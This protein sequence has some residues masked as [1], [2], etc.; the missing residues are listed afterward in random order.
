MMTDAAAR[1][2]V[3]AWLPEPGIVRRCHRESHDT[4][5]LHLELPDQADTQPR[6]K[7][8]SGQFNMLY[9]FGIG[10][11]PISISGVSSS[12]GYVQH[13]VKAAGALTR[14]M[15]E[16]KPDQRIGVRGP[17]GQ[18]WPLDKARKG[19]VLLIAGGIG[20]APVR[21]AMRDIMR[22]RSR[23]KRVDL[24]YGSRTPG[25]ILFHNQLKRWR[26]NKHVNVHVTVDHSDSTWD[27][28]VGFV[29]SLLPQLDIDPTNTTGLL[30]GP[31]IMMR[32]SMSQLLG[33][34]LPASSIHLSM[35]RNMRCAIGL[36]GHCQWGA[37]FVC[38]QGPV[39]SADKIRERLQVREL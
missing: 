27:G 8:H 35:E 3:P 37:D 15:T 34:G 24:I 30:C 39:F 19:N 21:A 25:D 18:G 2:A 1:S 7:P 36:C 16:L 17:F 5:T 22:H 6:P 4:V 12:T 20:M 10:E 14:A 29:T 26:N 32:H 33:L 11:A 31:E 38:Q 9:L 23:Y 28:P 13:T